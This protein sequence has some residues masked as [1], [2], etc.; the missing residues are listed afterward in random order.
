MRPDVDQFVVR[1]KQGPEAGVEAVQL[2]PIAPFNERV[3]LHPRREIV[4]M[5]NTLGNRG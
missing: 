4:E 5:Q 1:I 3:Y 2:A